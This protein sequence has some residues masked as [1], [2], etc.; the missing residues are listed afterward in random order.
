MALICVYQ[1]SKTEKFSINLINYFLIQLKWFALINTLKFA[2]NFAI[3]Y[4][5]S[6]DTSFSQIFTHHFVIFIR[7][8]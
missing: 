1:F 5:Y 6:R 4:D 3:T 8:K 7:I 2:T